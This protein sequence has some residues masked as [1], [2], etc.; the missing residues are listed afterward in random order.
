MDGA[1]CGHACCILRDAA[2]LD[3]KTFHD[4]A[5][6]VEERLHWEF[7]ENG[8]RAVLHGPL[9]EGD[10]IPLQRVWQG[11]GGEREILHERGPEIMV[12]ADGA[13]AGGF[14][15]DIF[16]PADYRAEGGDFGFQR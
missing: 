2:A 10:Q 1:G 11:I 13:D 15:G 14:V 4:I 16:Q 9:A 5:I 8:Q 6:D 7:L 12:T 3:G